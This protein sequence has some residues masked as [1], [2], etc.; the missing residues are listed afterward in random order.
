M[1]TCTGG[2]TGKTSYLQLID[3]TSSLQFTESF[4]M[5]LRYLFHHIM[6]YCQQI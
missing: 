1:K 4:R 2:E 6:K 3:K 5:L